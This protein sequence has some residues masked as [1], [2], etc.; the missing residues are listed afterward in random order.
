MP[1]VQDLTENSVSAPRSSRPWIRKALIITAALLLFLLC[2]DL[3]ATSFKLL[4]KET[5]E[6]ILAVTTNPFIGLFIGLLM[7]AIIQ[8]SST[9]TSL[10][11]TAVASGSLPVASAIPMILGA[12]IG[13]TLTSTIVALGYITRKKEF[14]KAIAAGTLH[15]FFNILVTLI[16]FPLEYYYGLLSGTAQWIVDSISLGAP[17]GGG[18]VFSFRLWSLVPIGDWISQTQIPPFI[19]LVISFGLLIL[20]IKFLSRSLSAVLIGESRDR[21]KTY[22]FGSRG[23]SFF[24]GTV[25]TAGV[26]SS[27]ITSALIVPFV[28]TNKVSLRKAFPFLMG[29]NIGTTIT[30]FI[31]ASF[32][33]EAAISLALAHLLFNL[34]GVIIFFLPYVREVPVYLA[35]QFGQIANK[36]KLAVFLY[37]TLT[38]FMFPFSLI[39]LH[40]AQSQPVNQEEQVQEQ[41]QETTNSP[42]AGR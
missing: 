18:A 42:F 12:N 34:V 3:M 24:W 22:L 17:Q 10:M 13:T 7:T 4:G 27:S 25:I 39:K 15:D 20:S 36:F 5:A 14:R 32:R 37:I 9:S 35:N 19:P 41:E 38:F 28:A 2:I 21:M 30:A 1:S 33:S 31:A 8:S 26:Q 23:R 29:A 11:V 40:E 6:N 16:V